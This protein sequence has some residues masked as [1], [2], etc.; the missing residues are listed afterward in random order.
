MRLVQTLEIDTGQKIN[1]AT[2]NCCGMLP[3][4][5][6][7]EHAEEIYGEGV[8]LVE[9]GTADEYEKNKIAATAPKGEDDR[10]Q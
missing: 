1:C 5:D 3:V 7:K 9:V 8:D 6:T 2:D 10:E 4:F